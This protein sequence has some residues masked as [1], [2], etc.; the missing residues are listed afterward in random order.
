M[1]EALN[2]SDN[3]NTLVYESGHA[4]FEQIAG[5]KSMM[6]AEFDPT[7]YVSKDDFDK[8]E[9]KVTELED[10]VANCEP[11]DDKELVSKINELN[12]QYLQIE[13]NLNSLLN[14]KVVLPYSAS[15]LTEKLGRLE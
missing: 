10:A 8:L 11:F 14:K 9:L 3:F 4:E 1:A 15:E 2:A 6:F 5:G 13:Y 7:K 12:S